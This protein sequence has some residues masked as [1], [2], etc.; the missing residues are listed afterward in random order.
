MRSKY[1]DVV[2]IGGQISGL[3]SAISLLKRGIKVLIIDA[4]DYF[5]PFDNKK[6]LSNSI[7][8]FGGF[9]LRNLL[10]SLGF[11]PLEINKLRAVDPAVQV[12]MPGIRFD[13]YSDEKRLLGELKRE[14]PD[15]WGEASKFFNKLSEYQDLYPK[16]F[17]SRVKFPPENFIEKYK[18][19]KFIKKISPLEAN[20]GKP[21]EKLLGGMSKNKDFLLLCNALV[22]TLS[23]LHL[24]DYSMP[25]L[26]QVVNTMRFEGYE[27][28]GGYK[29]FHDILISKVKE[30]GGIV[31]DK[32]E[33]KEVSVSG[34]YVD[35]LKLDK[36][37]IDKIILSY[38][39]VNGNPASIIKYLPSSRKNY[40]L[41][42]RLSKLNIKHLK[43]TFYVKLDAHVFPEGMKERTVLIS[44]RHG[45]L[46]GDNFLYISKV[47]ETKDEK[48]RKILTLAVSSRLNIK[49]FNDS[50]FIERYT[51]KCLERMEEIIPFMDKYLVGTEVPKVSDPK[52]ITGDLKNAFVYESSNTPFFGISALPYTSHFKNLF[53]VGKAIYPGLG[54][55]G[56]VQ[57]GLK[58][59]RHISDS[60]KVKRP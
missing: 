60:L 11:H 13:L 19:K 58:V 24:E 38:L 25:Y 56:E 40:I 45:E 39:I 23:D 7:M 15:I 12:I 52:E 18:L 49:D 14:F 36:H 6:A 27:F 42:K 28:E 1:F 37:S 9:T 50:E 59:S 16:L 48:G 32:G 2:F 41:R 31:L 8:Y 43:Y 53:F 4:Q 44:E 57:S 51:K 3:L 22:K 33:L 10:K 35:H 5:Y 20:G 55:D 21:L 29:S 54:F 34:R 47:D 30:R 46:I 26:S 17:M